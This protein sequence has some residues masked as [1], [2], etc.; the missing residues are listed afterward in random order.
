MGRPDEDTIGKR[1][2]GGKGKSGGS[3][4]SKGAGRGLGPVRRFAFKALCTDPFAANVIG[5]NGEARAEMEQDTGCSIWVS[6]RDEVYPFPQLRVLVLHADELE[7]ITKALDALVNKMVEVANRD[8]EGSQ[9]KGK[10][11]GEYV[12]HSALPAFIRGRLIGNRGA[13]IQNLREA[14]GAKI[15][16]ENENFDGHHAARVIA[17]P[18]IIQ[19]TMRCLNEIVQEEVGSDEYVTWVSRHG[20]TNPSNDGGKGKTKDRAGKG[21]KDR[22]GRDRGDRE[23]RSR[24]RERRH[25]S[26]SRDR[27]RD[28]NSHGYDNHQEESQ[29]QDYQQEPEVSVRF[30]DVS[31]GPPLLAMEDL[32]KEFPD[33]TLDATYSVSCDLPSKII[34]AMI[35][36]DY[37]RQIQEKTRTE[38]VIEDESEGLQHIM[39]QGPLLSSYYAHMLIMK[40]YQ[41]LEQAEREAALA[42]EEAARQEEEARQEAAAQAPQAATVEA[43]Q[44]QLQAL[45]S[46][47]A[48]VQQSQQSQQGGRS[49]GGKGSR[50]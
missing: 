39:I 43:L 28:Y 7:Q 44:A 35:A 49:R 31:E 38:I 6:K 21:G 47:L 34:V 25:R 15:F 10:E 20:L 29:E 24:D 14:T 3:K 22:G 36:Q 33:T 16:V 8:D 46:Q 40:A 42:A 17:S 41:D 37:V 5:K 48:E 23:R 27:T 11:D 9:M 2:G 12:F 18:D 19:K 32:A 26:R 30:G 50:R 45:Q 4:G 13:N 1:S